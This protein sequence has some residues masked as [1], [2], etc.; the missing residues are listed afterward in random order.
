MQSFEGKWLWNQALFDLLC[1]DMDET[2]TRIN[3]LL[4]K[5]VHN[6]E[7]LERGSVFATLLALGFI[8]RQ[9]AKSKD[10]SGLVQDKAQTWLDDRLDLMGEEGELIRSHQTHIKT[11]V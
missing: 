4:G 9:D 6:L 10:V 5:T 7:N 8:A 3:A 1:L 2:M 11:L